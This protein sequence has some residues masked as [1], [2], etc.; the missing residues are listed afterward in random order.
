MVYVMLC[1]SLCSP[2]PNPQVAWS[3]DGH[4]LAHSYVVAVCFMTPSRLLTT[5]WTSRLWTHLG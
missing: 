3:G 1:I 5:L 2:L 4:S